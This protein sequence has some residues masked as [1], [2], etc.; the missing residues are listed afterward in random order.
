MNQRSGIITQMI[1]QRTKYSSERARRGNRAVVLGLISNFV[2][3]G[4]KTSIGVLGHS[5]ALLAD[6]INSTSDVAYSL[7]V[8]IFVRLANKPADDEH[9]YGH[10]QLESIGAVVVGSFVITSAVAIFWNSI[11]SI[12]DLITGVSEFR[13]AMLIALWVAL[14]TVISKIGLAVYTN[15]VGKQTHNASVMALAYDHRNDVFSASAAVIGISLG[16]IG[17]AWVDPLAG[18]LVALVILRTGIEILRESTYDLM[19]TVPGKTLQKEVIGLLAQNQ[20]IEQV[21]DVHAHRFGPYLMINITICVE[22]SRTVEDGDM[23]ATWVEQT[24]I[25][26]IPSVRRVHVHYHPCR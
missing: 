8:S 26:N 1:D 14:F 24:L 6:G 16:R 7:V 11:D 12:Y 25:S 3:A 17:Y 18:A 5:P 2:L 9:P 21:D 19:D 10:S 13:G 23:I 4:L 15:R 22:G 20:Q